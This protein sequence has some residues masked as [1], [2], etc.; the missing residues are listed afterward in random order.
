MG[1]LLI[2][3]YR[4]DPVLGYRSLFI[5]AFGNFYGFAET[6][7]YAMPLAFTGL[8]FSI[9]VRAGLFN[10]GSEGQVYIGAIAAV[11]IG[12]LPLGVLHPMLLIAFSGLAGALWSLIPSLLKIFRGVHEVISTIMLNWI[13]YYITIYIS[14]NILVDP[15]RPEKTLSILE[16]ARLPTIVPGT[17]LTSGIYV[18]LVIAVIF[19]LILSR[20]VIGY[21]IALVGAGVDVARYAGV[22]INK[23]IIYSF[24][25]GGLA[26]GIAG[27]L[28]I[29][30]KPPTYALYGNLGNVSG[31]GFEGIGVALIGRNNPLGIIAASILYG[32]IKNGGRYMEYQA[33]IDSDL[34]RA[35]NG[36]F[37]IALSMPELL[38]IIRRVVRR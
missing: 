11:A 19:Y 12:I 35:L 21:E 7:S 36:L 1:A 28:L 17:T 27:G 25:L 31:Y 4:Y 13:S 30:A 24:L 5:G 26:S 9:G 3:I 22:N 15:S 23:I 34:V 37:V 29:A 18:S 32:G 8:T 6:L 16:S 33:G 38:R 20:T 10:I 2:T 14:S